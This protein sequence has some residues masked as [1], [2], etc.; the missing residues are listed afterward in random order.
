MSR[1]G[2]KRAVPH[3]SVNIEF[4]DFLDRL[5]SL[6]EA[7][8]EHEARLRMLEHERPTE[9]DLYIDDDEEDK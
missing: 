2:T 1:L 6:E 7:C 9:G 8:A 4:A 3:S 5:R